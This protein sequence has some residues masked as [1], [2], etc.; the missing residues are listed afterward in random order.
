MS[1]S[2]YA[3]CGVRRLGVGGLNVRKDWV[4]TVGDTGLRYCSHRVGGRTVMFRCNEGIV[5]RSEKE[6]CV[7]TAEWSKNGAL[8]KTYLNNHRFYR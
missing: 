5:A 6:G 8:R 4:K 2:K 7:H 1:N 3:R